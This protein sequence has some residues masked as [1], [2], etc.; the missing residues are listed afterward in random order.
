MGENRKKV[1]SLS[2]LPPRGQWFPRVQ[3]NI[4]LVLPLLE[5]LLVLK[6]S[7]GDSLNPFKVAA[8]E[9]HR[10]VILVK[11]NGLVKSYFSPAT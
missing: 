2:F 6:I 5:S 9:I 4:A 11:N 10:V 7:G 1:L 3:F 8:V